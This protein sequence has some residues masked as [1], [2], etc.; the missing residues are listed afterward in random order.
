DWTDGEDILRCNKN[1][2]KN[3]PRY[4]CVLYNSDQPGLAC[5]RLRALIRCKL[6][7]GRIADLAIVQAMQPSHW[8]PRTVWD[9]CKVYGEET[10]FSFLLMDYVIR[11]ALFTPVEP[12]PKSQS[13]SHRRPYFLV[14]VTDGDMFLR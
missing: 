4:D 7:S 3:G 14:D 11:G 9:G 13:R 12:P 1:W 10:E 6:P 2:Y 8:K 5:A